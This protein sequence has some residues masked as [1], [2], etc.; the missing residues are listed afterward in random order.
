MMLPTRI[1]DRFG[2]WITYQWSSDSFAHLVSMSAGQ[3]G[4]TSPDQTI[5][6]YYQGN[7]ITRVSD[8]TRDW[9]YSYIGDDVDGYSL[10]AVTLPDGSQWHYSLSGTLASRESMLPFCDVDLD[11]DPESPAYYWYCYGGGEVSNELFTGFVTSPSGATATYSFQ[12]HHHLTSS[13]DKTYVL[14]LVSKTISG[15]G[16]PTATWRYS[17]MPDKATTKT[18]CQAGA[19]PSRF[20]TDLVNPDNSVTRRL[21]DMEGILHGELRGSIGANSGGTQTITNSPK[22]GADPLDDPKPQHGGYPGVV[23]R[24]NLCLRAFDVDALHGAS[25]SQSTG[26]RHRSGAGVPE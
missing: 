10:S 14:G 7:R 15:A 11:V 18:Q 25:G 4:S 26:R 12:L 23:R 19:C 13:S 3:A 5:T 9:L 17:Y 24:A 8:G 22:W 16:L 6:A 20:V 1:E 2:N 21:F